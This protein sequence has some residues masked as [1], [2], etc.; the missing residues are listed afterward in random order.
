MLYGASDLELKSLNRK[1]ATRFLEQI[2]KEYG[3]DA[4]AL[5]IND[6]TFFMSEANKIFIIKNSIKEVNL[7]NLRINSLGLYFC[8][9]N[10][11]QIRLS[12]EGSLMIGKIATK[13]I[14]E[15]DGVMA[16]EWLKGYDLEIDQ[17]FDGFIIIKHGDD[18][19]GCGRYKEGRILNY[20]SKPRRVKE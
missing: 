9:I 8:E 5:M 13:N 15:V 3:C 20:V 1:E 7:N 17:K 16:R 12:M 14:L 19:M 18:Y 4:E 11:G 2:S 6:Y 10:H